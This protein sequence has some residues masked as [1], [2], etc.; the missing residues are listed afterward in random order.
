MTYI[1]IIDNSEKR[2]HSADPVTEAKPM[3][4]LYKG[5]QLQFWNTEEGFMEE[6]EFKPSGD[7]ES[8]ARKK[9]LPQ[10][11]RRGGKEH[12]RALRFI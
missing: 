9:P 5:G 8:Q 4:L 6:E 11:R 12:S 10:Q 3:C 7:G 1:Q 2:Q